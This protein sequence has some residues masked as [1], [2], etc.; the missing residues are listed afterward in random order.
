MDDK[1]SKGHRILLFSQFT[2]MLD[3]IQERLD[4]GSYFRIDGTVKTKDRMDMVNRFNMG[5][6][7]I[8]L[9]SLRAGGTGLNLVGAD[10]VIHFDPWWNPAVEDQVTDR[11]YRI[12]Q[13]NR[14]E[15]FKLITKNTIE[16]KINELKDKKRE[17]ANSI[18]KTGETFIN[19]LSE[20]E[21]VNI[22]SE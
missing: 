1:V 5:E 17:V 15:V 13:E 11:A 16:E 8:F 22:L 20:D 9:I 21:L 18:I 14:V 4:K 7:E 19:K 2:S 3:I 12:G 6:K 10:T